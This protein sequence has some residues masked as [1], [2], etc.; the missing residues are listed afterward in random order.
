MGR[1]RVS[2]NQPLIRW[3]FSPGVRFQVPTI[4]AVL[5]YIGG[6]FDANLWQ[7][8][9]LGADCVTSFCDGDGRFRFAPGFTAKAGLGIR[10][11]GP[12]YLD[13][14]L[15][16]SMSGP[17]KFF[18]DTEWWVEPFIGFLYRGGTNRF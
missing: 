4:D 16:T 13:V 10:L 15:K 3:H 5:P 7:L 18:E 6:R 1:L 8:Q 14:G 17:G 11:K 2:G 9:A 12:W